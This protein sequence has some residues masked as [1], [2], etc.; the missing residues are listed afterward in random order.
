MVKEALGVGWCYV[1]DGKNR[2]G[3]MPVECDASI[4]HYFVRIETL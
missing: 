4:L 2:R 3:L 1:L